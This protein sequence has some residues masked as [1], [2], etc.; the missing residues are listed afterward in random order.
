MLAR[1][2]SQAEEA[3]EDQRASDRGPHA[4]VHDLDELGRRAPRD[5][6]HRVHARELVVEVREPA[7]LVD[8]R[9]AQVLDDVVDRERDG[10]E[11][12][13]RREA[14]EPEV[15]VER[16]VVVRR[17]QLVE[18]PPPLEERAEG[19]DAERR[20]HEPDGDRPA[21]VE[22]VGEPSVRVLLDASNALQNVE[23]VALVEPVCVSRWMSG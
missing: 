14:H 5:R 4:E 2:L 11:D 12:L 17:H 18:L 16:Q 15:A 20:G 13:D 23:P 19:E 10:E 7:E 3:E 22:D 6:G 21:D 9:D 1:L 8:R